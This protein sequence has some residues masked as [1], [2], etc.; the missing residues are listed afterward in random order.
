MDH[1]LETTQTFL[2]IERRSRQDWPWC[3]GFI[4]KGVLYS[5]QPALDDAGE[6]GALVDRLGDSQR[7]SV[8]LT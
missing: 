7:T 8:P 6:D 1:E 4:V 5:S 2:P 3:K